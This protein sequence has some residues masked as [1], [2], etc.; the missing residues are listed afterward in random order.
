MSEDIEIDQEFLDK[1]ANEME[2]GHLHYLQDQMYIVNTEELRE[3]LQ[4]Q[5]GDAEDIFAQMTR[6]GMYSQEVE[7]SPHLSATFRTITSK[8][9]D[10]C[11]SYAREHATTKNEYGRLLARRRLSYSLIEQND[12]VISEPIDVPLFE[13]NSPDSDPMD[14]LKENADNAI[15]KLNVLPDTLVNRLSQSFGVWEKIV[16]SR[17]QEAEVAETVKN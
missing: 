3:K 2:E 6:R 5:V 12:Q 16:T 8:A 13:L 9:Q 15:D 4:N 17:I 10:E 14:V 1:L 11:M 7:V